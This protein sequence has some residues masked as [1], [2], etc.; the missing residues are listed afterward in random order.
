MMKIRAQTVSD[1]FPFRFIVLR[2]YFSRVMT[3]DQIL[4]NELIS[5]FLLSPSSNVRLSAIGF[6]HTQSLGHSLLIDLICCILSS[7]A[8]ILTNDP[9]FGLPLHVCILSFHNSSNWAGMSP[10]AEV[11][12]HSPM[13]VLLI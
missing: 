1:V 10:L 6:V 7:V 8:G 5:L 9:W 3:V 12:V 13:H 4:F 11:V 2:V